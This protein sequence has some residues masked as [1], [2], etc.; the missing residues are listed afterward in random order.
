MR[1]E[2]V[3]LEPEVVDLLRRLP[4]GMALRVLDRL[5]F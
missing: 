1:P 5:L 2:D 4:S 3:Y